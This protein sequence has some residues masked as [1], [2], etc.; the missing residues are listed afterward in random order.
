MGLL[1]NIRRNC[2][3]WREVFIHTPIRLDATTVEQ[4]FHVNWS[5]ETAGGNR[6]Q[7]ERRTITQWRDLLQDLEGALFSMK[8]W[9]PCKLT[10]YLR[11]VDSMWSV[12][13]KSLY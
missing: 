4:I 12:V 9:A 6:F 13:L 10:E 11:T 7:K 5:D 3:L 8:L 2:D 1:Q